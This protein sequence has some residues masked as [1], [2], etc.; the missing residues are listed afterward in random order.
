VGG[1]LCRASESLFLYEHAALPSLISA[2]QSLNHLDLTSNLAPQLRKSPES[3]QGLPCLDPPSVLSLKAS[4]PQPRG[5]PWARCVSF[6]SFLAVLEFELRALW[7]LGRRSTTWAVPSLFVP[8]LRTAVL[9][10][11]L[12]SV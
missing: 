8:F 5:I 11:L 7:L 3:P 6:I 4:S 10:C 9:H 12:S 2:P 1:I